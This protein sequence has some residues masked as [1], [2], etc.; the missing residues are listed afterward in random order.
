MSITLQIANGDVVTS[1]ISGRPN[2][3]KDRDALKQHLSENFTI[4]TLPNG[5]GVGMRKLIGI[6]PDDTTLFT[7]LING[8]L[9]NSIDAIRS[10]QRSTPRIPRPAAERVSALT[11]IT[12]N[13]DPNDPRNYL[14]FADISTEDGRSVQLTGALSKG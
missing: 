12:V 13:Q 10:L 6:E 4:D 2:T 14:Y 8:K 11:F 3:I 9:R 5:M 7:M 1:Q